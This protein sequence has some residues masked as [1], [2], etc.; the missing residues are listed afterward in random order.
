MYTVVFATSSYSRYVA[1]ARRYSGN[2]GMSIIPYL[3]HKLGIN[4]LSQRR[5]GLL[6]TRYVRKKG[7]KGIRGRAFRAATRTRERSTPPLY[8]ERISLAFRVIALDRF[9]APALTPPRYRR[10]CGEKREMGG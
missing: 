9:L 1:T 5:N 7:A 4:S 2:L 8:G 10:A 3:S 6:P